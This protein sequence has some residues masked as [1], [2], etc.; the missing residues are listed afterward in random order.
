MADYSLLIILFA[1][2]LGA[3]ALIFVPRKEEFLTRMVA[4]VSSGICLLASA[5]IFFA[6]DTEKSG[7]QFT[8]KFA[9]SEELGISFYVGVDGIGGPLVFA[10]AILLFAGIFVSWHIKDRTKEFYIF[11]LI[12][13]AATIGVFMSLD[14]FFLYFFYEMSV[15]PMYVLLGIWGSHTKGYLSMTDPEGIKL[16]DSVGYILNFGSNSKEYAA[17]KLTLFLSAGA[18]M[19]LMGILLIYHFSGMHT[20]DI[21]ELRKNANFSGPLATIIWLLVFFG[22]ASIAPIW[23]LHSWS[24]VGHAAAPAATSM[25][26]A[27]VLMKLGHFSIIRVGYE[28]LPDT[29]RELIPIAAILCVFSIV[30]GGLVSYFAKDTKYVIGYSSSSHMG[31]I[32]LGMAALDYISLTGAVIYMFAHALATGMLFAMAGWVYDQTHTRDI[33]S[34]G[35]LMEKMPFLSGAFIV[36]CMASIGMPGTVNF[37]AEIMII[38]GSWQKYPFQVIVAILGI[39][40]TMAY[41]FR[42]MRGLFYGQLDP[43][44]AH[45]QDAKAFVDRLPLLIMIFF[46]ISLGIFPGHFYNVVRSS[47]EPLLD[48]INQ[49]APLI[50]QNS[51]GLLP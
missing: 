47:V 22:F 41:L 40:L 49:V 32:F 31:Y 13:A 44:Y 5:Y 3:I 23:P 37:I 46:S 26:H 9:W 30:Y 7:F 12:L 51:T 18:V 27:G 25:L 43:E 38:V 50:T 16:R 19:A 45:A 39:V 1:P 20:F 21:V 24:P 42:M 29:T 8:Q 28:I 33:P 11:L 35:G 4:V 6:Y 36:A 10:S 15:L 48:R 34:L 17:M 2:F 14:L